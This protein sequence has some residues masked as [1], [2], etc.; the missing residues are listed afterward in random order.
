MGLASFVAATLLLSLPASLTP[1]GPA[2]KKKHPHHAVHGVVV[3]VQ[4]DKDKDSGSI[5]VRVHQPKK[6]KANQQATLTTFHVT[7]AT[8]FERVVVQASG[9]RQ[10]QPAMFTDIHKGEHLAIL[11]ARGKD[12]IAKT[13]AI[14]VHHHKKKKLK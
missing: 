9:K 6:G 1:A 10:V 7:D 14:R 11:P 13:V 2:A 5:T 3:S 12:H 4:K 8:K